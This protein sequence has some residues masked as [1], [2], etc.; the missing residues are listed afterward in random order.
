MANSDLLEPARTSDRNYNALY[1]LNLA[2]ENQ[3]INLD[4]QIGSKGCRIIKPGDAAIANDRYDRLLVIS[5]NTVLATISDNGQ[6]ILI[7][8]GFNLT[9]L[10]IPAIITSL[11]TGAGLSNITLTSGLVI[12]YYR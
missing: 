4:R 5:D 3:K 12:A 7:P 9:A 10:T 6:S 1:Y 2:L 11:A 8:N